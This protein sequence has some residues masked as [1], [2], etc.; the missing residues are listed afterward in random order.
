MSH[1]VDTLLAVAVMV[2]IMFFGMSIAQAQVNISEARSCK[3]EIIAELEN[4]AYNPAVI[5]ECIRQAGEN[6]YTLSVT[7][8]RKGQEKVIYTSAD[9]ENAAITDVRA[10]EVVLGYKYRLTFLGESSVHYIR[11]FAR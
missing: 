11:G 9:I 7:L 3:E 6:G 5:N 8:Y 4:G 1:I 2:L 10:A